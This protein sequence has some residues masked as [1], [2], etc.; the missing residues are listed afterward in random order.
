MKLVSWNVNGLRA[1]L[2]KGFG[3]Y[4]AACGADIICLQEVRALPGEI[5]LR[6]PGYE[7]HWNPARKRGY[8]G[9]AILTRVGLRA[10][11]RGMGASE[12]DGEGRVIAAELDGFHL[13]SV[14]TPNSQ[15]GLTRLD[16]RVGE[17]DPA[18]RRYVKEL[19]KTKPVVFCGDLNVAHA[20]I[21]LANPAS[22]RN[23]AG[24]TDRE[25]AAFGKLLDAGFVDTF[26]QF[27]KGGG[28]YTWWSNFGRARE[29]NV[30]WRIDYFCVSE[31]LRPR[32]KA[33]A[34][35]PEITGSDHCPISLELAVSQ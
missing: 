31:A 25:R 4:A 22:N 21:D 14:Y 33:A 35:H 28:H 32:L 26:R 20:E 15:R 2:K 12:H 6:L 23:N 24:F 29:R 34:I 8:S 13:V 10:V 5:D 27:E 18:F 3:E 16:Y 7:A 1:A 30:G 19:E 9:T 17:W 11:T